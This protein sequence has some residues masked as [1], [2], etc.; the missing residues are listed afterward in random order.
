MQ[1]W[2]GK[3]LE[4]IA[5]TFGFIIHS[6]KWSDMLLSIWDIG[7]QSSIRSFWRNYFERTDAI[8]WV[9]DSSAPER[10]DLCR[11]ELVK[12][13]QEQRLLS[14]SLLILANKQDLPG[15][16]SLE[17][18]KVALAWDWLQTR[19]SCHVVACSAVLGDGVM[20]GLDW[21]VS[22]VAKRL[23]FKPVA[24]TVDC[25]TVSV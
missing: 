2:L 20:E 6:L 13:M 8:V 23:Y 19:C 21:L 12:V 14:A 11:G 10:L 5:P 18:I 24:P 1:R 3:D 9:V 7:G 17:S 15:A 22:D 4:G 16:A 25:K